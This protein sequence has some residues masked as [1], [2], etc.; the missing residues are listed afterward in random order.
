VKNYYCKAAAGT[1]RG[2]SKKGNINDGGKKQKTFLIFATRT[3]SAGNRSN[4]ENG[5]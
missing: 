5:K 3:I 2:E 1:E 4:F